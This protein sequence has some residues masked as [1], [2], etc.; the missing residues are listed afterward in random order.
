MLESLLN[1]LAEELDDEKGR[2]VEAKGHVVLGGVVADGLY[3]LKVRIDKEAGGVE[4]AGSLDHVLNRKFIHN[5]GCNFQTNYLPYWP[6]GID[7][8]IF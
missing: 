5:E 8:R 3:C 2:K 1:L 6:Q 4:E 7:W